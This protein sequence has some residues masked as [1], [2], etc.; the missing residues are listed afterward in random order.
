MEPGA[1]ITADEPG[2]ARTLRI[3]DARTGLEAIVVVDNVACGLGE[4]LA[5]FAAATP[6]G[7][8]S[9]APPRSGRTG[10]TAS[11]AS[12]RRTD[13]APRPRRG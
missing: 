5:T 8:L 11:P 12:P 3:H 1:G 6:T 2:T 7:E 13:P 9:R 4:S 10:R